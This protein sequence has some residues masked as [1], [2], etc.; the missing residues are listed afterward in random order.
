MNPKVKKNKLNIGHLNVRSLFT[1]FNEFCD[2][3]IQGD[4]DVFCVS[5]TWLNDMIPAEIVNIQN[6]KFFYKN[7]INRG[8]GV[9][10]YVR[11]E[12]DAKLVLSDFKSIDGLE[13]LFL[14]VKIMKMQLLIGVIYRVPSNN[15]NE[16]VKHLDDLLSF[17]VPQYNNI[18]FLGDINIDQQNENSF[19]SCMS[20]YDF[21]QLIN[22]PTRIT[23]TSQSIIDVIYI[24]KP[25][26]IINSGTTNADLISDHRLI[27]CNMNINTKRPKPKLVTYRD[28]K[29]FVYDEFLRDL[30]KVHWDDILYLQSIE[31]K[32]QFL[33]NNI[34]LLFDNH[35][36]Y[37]T[38]RVTKPYAPWLTDNVKFLMKERD[39]AL[40]NYKI[41]NTIGSWNYYKQLRNFTVS[42]IRREKAAYLTFI[43]NQQNNSKELWHSLKTLNIQRK[44]DVDIP[45]SLRKPDEVNNYFASVF[46]PPDNC[47]DMSDWYRVNKFKNDIVFNFKL[48]TTGQVN[49]LINQLKSNAYG[50]DKVS[51]K[52]LQ[53]CSPVICKYVTHILNCCLEVGYFPD[54]WK[55]SLIKPISKNN[56]PKSFNDLRPITII[57]A[58]SKL[59]EKTVKNQIYDYVINNSI[60]SSFQSGFRK[61][62]STTSVLM[63][64]TDNI[65]KSLDD[66]NASALILLDFSKAFDTLDHSLLCAKLTYY[67]FSD[68]AVNFF[69]SYL[70]NRHQIVT[71]DDT[72]SSQCPITSGV[73]QGSVLGPILFLIYT[74]DIVNNVHFTKIQCYADDTQLSLTFSPEDIASASVKINDDLKSILEYSSANNLKL[75]LTKCHVICFCSRTVR[76]IIE[77]S[78]HVNLDG[79]PLNMVH[80]VKNLGLIFETD[81]RFKEYVKSLIRRCYVSLKLLY[82]NIS[83]INFKLRKKLVETLVLPI[84]NYCNIVYFPCLDS[85]TKNRLQIIQNSCCRFIFR[86]KKYDHVS[87]KINELKWLKIE[88]VYKYNLLVFVHKLIISST[89][90]YLREKLIFRHDLHDVN[91]RFSNKLSLPRYHSTMFQRS[92]SYN[93]VVLYNSLNSDLK[94]LPVNSFRKQVK[95]YFFSLQM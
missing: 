15:I 37:T 31:E 92:F 76:N 30:G 69:G 88:N 47:S 71:F 10:I 67:G 75:N 4:Y 7:R 78:L 27:F 60:V 46:S 53:L 14:N 3:L 50:S 68:I 81:L 36:P 13:Y 2:L 42:A 95:S 58:I 90:S 79:Q 34:L 89:P 91:T 74:A 73:P 21:A 22:E 18:I 62:H 8:G 33:N 72:N 59:L 40:S 55:L 45:F 26:F 93:A 9:G 70:S 20:S 44:Q 54:N 16:S 80:K 84:L 65:F 51:A 66:G 64:V 41:L 39:R 52:M 56:D 43:Q 61:N 49:T 29:N 5:E 48:A 57:P 24:N 6:Y 28:F 23:N 17:I 83:I 87:A 25:E 77:S 85:L 32:V 63:S 12:I 94:Q 38:S 35:A 1:G 86:I 11:N 19:D 82:T